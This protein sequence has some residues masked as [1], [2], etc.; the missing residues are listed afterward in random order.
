MRQLVGDWA[1]QA[2]QSRS[3]TVLKDPSE[4][5]STSSILV[6]FILHSTRLSTGKIPFDVTSEGLDDVH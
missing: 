3:I 4:G 1:R 5:V 6:G 2:D